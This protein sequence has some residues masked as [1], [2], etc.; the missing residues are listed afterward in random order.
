MYLPETSTWPS[1]TQFHL[2]ILWRTLSTNQLL[3]YFVT[4]VVYS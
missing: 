1:V 2:E 4:R 3:R